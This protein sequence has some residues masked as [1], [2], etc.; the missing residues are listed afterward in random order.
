MRLL[1]ELPRAFHYWPNFAQ[2]A[3]LERVFIMREGQNI[4]DGEQTPMGIRNCA[5]EAAER[6]IELVR[7]YEGLNK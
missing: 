4:P 5:T 6:E 1:Y 7:N 2:D 3:Y